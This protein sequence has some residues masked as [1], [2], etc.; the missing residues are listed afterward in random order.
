MQYTEASAQKIFTDANLRPLKR[1]TDP[2][3]GFSLWL[4]ERPPP[5]NASSLG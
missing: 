3:S 2:D 4:L 5:F 1:W